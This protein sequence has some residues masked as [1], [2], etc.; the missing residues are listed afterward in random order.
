MKKSKI[1]KTGFYILKSRLFNKRMPISV[2]FSVTNK[3]NFNCKYCNRWKD[4][5]SE[6]STEEIFLLFDELAEM[7][8]QNITLF[9]GEPLLRKDIEKIIGYGKKKGFFMALNSN[10]Y[11]LPERFN[12]INNTDLLLISLDGSRKINDKLR[13]KGSYNSIVKSIKLANENEIPVITYTVLTRFNINQIDFILN[14]AEKLHFKASFL[15]L[16]KEPQTRKGINNFD[17]DKRQYQEAVNKLI[18]YKKSGKPIVN[19]LEG[20]KYMYNIP[21]PTKKIRCWAGKLHIYIAPDGRVYSCCSIRQHKKEG[22][23]FPSISLKEAFENLYIDKGRC[24]KQK[25]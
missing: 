25:I 21:D 20:L 9:G 22:K 17:P 11:L 18:R 24:K 4:V 19:S 3:C 7:G 6:L 23:T 8:T 15:Y 10:A 16:L 1:I 14:K 12:D 13:H 5:K 2:I